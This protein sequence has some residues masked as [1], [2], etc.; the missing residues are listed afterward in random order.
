[1]GFNKHKRISSA[2]SYK[3]NSIAG[4][5]LRREHKQPYGTKTSEFVNINKENLSK[6]FDIKHLKTRKNSKRSGYNKLYFY[7]YSIK[8]F[9]HKLCC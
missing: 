4:K 3:G 9:F 7:L 6:C 8:C 2:E 1:M 5:R